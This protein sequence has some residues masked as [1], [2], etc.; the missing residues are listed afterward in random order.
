MVPFAPLLT[1]VAISLPLPLLL[2]FLLLHSIHDGQ[3][4]HVLLNLRHREPKD[5]TVVGDLVL[6]LAIKWFVVGAR[7]SNYVASTVNFYPRFHSKTIYYST[8]N[9]H[10]KDR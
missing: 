7:V 10:H 3:S 6:A 4:P 1:L 8:T 2:P 9:R 5:I